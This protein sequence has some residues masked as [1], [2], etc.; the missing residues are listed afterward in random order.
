MKYKYI[1]IPKSIS[2]HEC[3]ENGFVFAPSKY[4]RFLPNNGWLFVPMSQICSESKSKIRIVKEIEYNYSEIGDIDISSGLVGQTKYFGLNLPA[5]NPKQCKCG[6]ILIST[7]RTYRGGIGMITED[8]PNHCCSPAILI[9]RNV[10]ENIITKEYLLAILKSLFFTE[11]I[12]GFQ[13]RGMYPRLDSDAMDKVLIPIPKNKN[14]IKYITALQKSC[15]QKEKLIH[16]RHADILQLIEKELIENQKPNTFIYQLPRLN[17]V[18][19]VGRIDTS[20]FGR[21]FKSKIFVILNYLNGFKSIEDWGFKLSRGQNL[22][23][24]N[25]GKSVY[26]QTWYPSFYTLVL[27]M[28]LSKYGTIEDVRFLGNR[29]SLKTLK[30]GDLIFG[31]EGFEKGRSIVVIEEEQNTITN[32]HGITIQHGSNDIILS[33][34]IKCFLD[35]LRHQG[36][37]DL[38]AVGG[39]GGSLAQRYWS[40]IPFPNFPKPKQKEIAT[41]Y[42]NPQKYETDCFTLENFLEKDDEF[43]SKAGIYELDKTAKMLKDKLNKAIDD[44]VNDREVKI[45]W[46]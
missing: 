37:I 21:N 4:S 15:L 29:N 9:I 42:H 7:V 20:M 40:F 14:A 5:E 26:S 1:G 10:D 44:I 33:I 2:F 35:Y 17:D 25:I 16:E 30:K 28:F 31:A 13:T 3:Y 38:F 46:E 45:S 39:N 34:Y 41:L 6:D 23:V 11:Q 19:E 18:K 8:L 32:I 36:L 22:Q 43:N 27:P 24:S 12:L